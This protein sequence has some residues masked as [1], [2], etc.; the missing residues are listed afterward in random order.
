MNICLLSLPI[1][2]ILSGHL[3]YWRKVL[4]ITIEVPVGCMALEILYGWEVRQCPD[5]QL[6]IPVTQRSA[7]VGPYL[8]RCGLSQ[9]TR[10]TKHGTVFFPRGEGSLFHFSIQGQGS[11]LVQ[12]Q[13]CCLL[14]VQSVLSLAVREYQ[15]KNALLWRRMVIRDNRDR[16]RVY[17]FFTVQTSLLII[18]TK[19]RQSW[20]PL[21][22]I[23]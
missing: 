7:R 17:S 5:L 9:L 16:D 15:A 10:E 22:V 12:T 8:L 6:W 1:P 3:G 14:F 21:N 13:L 2:H 19:F 11:A 18:I 23:E 4:G 20:G